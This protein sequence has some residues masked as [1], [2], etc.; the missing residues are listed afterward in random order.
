[1]VAIDDDTEQDTAS[2]SAS[3]CLEAPVLSEA[4]RVRLLQWLHWLTEQLD[5][6]P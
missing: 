6:E 1:M 5:A 2:S 4:Q 3:P